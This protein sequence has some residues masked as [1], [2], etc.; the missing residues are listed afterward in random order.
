M[1]YYTFAL[2]YYMFALN[3][4]ILLRIFIELLCTRVIID[5][6]RVSSERSESKQAVAH[7]VRSSGAACAAVPDVVRVWVQIQ[8]VS[9]TYRG[10]SLIRNSHATPLA[11]ASG[12]GSSESSESKEA[13]AHRVRSSA[14]TCAAA[15]DAVGALTLTITLT[16]THIQNHSHSHS[17]SHKLPVSY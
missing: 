16:H 6:T 12:A 2:N 10:T 15:T 4:Y 7:R 5:Y 9:R 17:Y 3:H 14:A 1:S 11:K 8:V 13:L